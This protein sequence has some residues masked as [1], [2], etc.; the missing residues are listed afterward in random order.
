MVDVFT[1]KAFAG[2]PTCVVFPT[3]AAAFSEVWMRKVSREMAQPTTSFVDLAAK[4][5]RIFGANGLESP[6][7]S[8]HSSLGV[9]AATLART[10]GRSISLASKYGDVGLAFDGEM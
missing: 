7:L 3:T 6:I 2:N 9:A 1:N 5:F 8:G 4:C 10:G